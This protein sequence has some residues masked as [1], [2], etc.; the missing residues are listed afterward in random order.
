LYYS[1][2]QPE[3]QC[4]SFTAGLMIRRTVEIFRA[5]LCANAGRAESLVMLEKLCAQSHETK[6]PASRPS[7]LVLDRTAFTN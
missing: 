5:L 4:L 3:A 6:L 2:K 1:F 7:S